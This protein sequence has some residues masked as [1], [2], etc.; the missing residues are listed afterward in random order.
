[1]HW[2]DCLRSVFDSLGFCGFGVLGFLE[3]LF[4]EHWND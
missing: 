2:K 1:M 3:L 4:V